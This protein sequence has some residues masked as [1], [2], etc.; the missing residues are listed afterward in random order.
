MTF[1]QL[2]QFP[3]IFRL[4]FQDPFDLYNIC[5]RLIIYELKIYSHINVIFIFYVY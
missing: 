2:F 1:G 4:K 3:Y 5:I